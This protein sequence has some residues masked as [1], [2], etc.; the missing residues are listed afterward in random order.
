MLTLPGMLKRQEEPARVPEAATQEPRVLTPGEDADRATRRMEQQ[1]R[2]GKA[3]YPRPGDPGRQEGEPSP[4][5][6]KRR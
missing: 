4:A 5:P 1:E 6:D 2:L 3:V